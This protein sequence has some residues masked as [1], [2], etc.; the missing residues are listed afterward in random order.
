[1]NPAYA[2]I[3]GLVLLLVG[4][5]PTAEEQRAMDQQRCGGFGFA[6]GT[7]AFAHCMMSISQ[8]REAQEAADRRASADRDAANKRSQAAIQATKDKADR[9]A[10]D[11]QAAQDSSG[12][13]SSSPFSSSNPVDQVRNSIERDM[14]KVEGSQ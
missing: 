10:R 14:Q 13:T 1:M 2:A 12:S 11:K 3:A 7:D 4:C 9:D 6:A 5:G 8:Q